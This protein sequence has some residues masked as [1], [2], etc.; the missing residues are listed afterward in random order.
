[1]YKH[2]T[3]INQS[4][5]VQVQA[6]PS[7]VTVINWIKSLT[8]QV[9]P[10]IRVEDL[11]S[12]VVYCQIL[13]YYFGSVIPSNKIILAPKDESQCRLNLKLFEKAA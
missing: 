6:S 3:P 4:N 7:K 10:N 12:G 1:M 8:S 2:R 13:N 5:R 9:S 11:G